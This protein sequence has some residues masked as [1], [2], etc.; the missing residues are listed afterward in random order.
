MKRWHIAILATCALS[1]LLVSQKSLHAQESPQR[2]PELGPAG[3]VSTDLRAAE[4]LRDPEETPLISPQPPVYQRP[5]APA[6]VQD[7]RTPA[8]NVSTQPGFAPRGGG[9]QPQGG[10]FQP[11]GAS[12]PTQQPPRFEPSSRPPYQPQVS[13]VPPQ[14]Q[15]RPPYQPPYQPQGQPG[16]P[17]RTPQ[18]QRPPQFV[19]QRQNSPVQPAGAQ[20][21][22]E[23]QSQL[24]SPAQIIARV[25][26]ETILAGDIQGNV[27]QILAPYEG[28]APKAELDRQRKLLMQ[29]ALKVAIETKLIYFDFLREI[30]KENVANIEESLTAAFT[31]SRLPVLMKRANVTS[32]AELDAK[33]RKY[34]TSVAKARQVFFE[35]VMAQQK[36]QRE[37]DQDP[38]VTHQEMLDY[39]KEHL[40]DYE[41][42]PK[43]RWEHLMAA[44]SQFDGDRDRTYRHLAAMGNEVLGGAPLEAVAK[45]SSHGV[46]ADRGGFHDWTRQGSLASQKIDTA[47]FSLPL[48]QL[49]RPIVDDRGYHIVRVVERN[50]AGYVSFLEAQVGIKE[51]IQKAKMDKQREAYLTKVRSNVDVWTI[52]DDQ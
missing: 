19:A 40:Q 49:S 22:P 14:Y 18:Q 41:I 2:F 43:A 8:R 24:F 48:N 34:G 6:P 7:L 15:Q 12:G 52:F 38:E 1:V 26:T 29:Q 33:F 17:P 50:P 36:L 23:P 32:A 4:L 13:G 42:K 30:P 44:F 28:K 46:N 27:N 47:L 35:Q 37:I 3:G 11:G 25:G 31:D 45:R 39:Y 10:A 5:G 21:K 9:F 20:A 51:K 16:F